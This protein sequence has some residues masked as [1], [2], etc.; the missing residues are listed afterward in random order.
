MGSGLQGEYLSLLSQGGRC[1]SRLLTALPIALVRGTT[2][3]AYSQHLP[4]HR[5]RNAEVWCVCQ[6]PVRQAPEVLRR[7]R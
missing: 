1:P 7:L 3:R 2:Y 4:P 6:R 5:H